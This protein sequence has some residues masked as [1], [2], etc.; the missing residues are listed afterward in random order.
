MEK[1]KY[2]Q[3]N[4]AFAIA[5]KKKVVYLQQIKLTKLNKEYWTLRTAVEKQKIKS[6]FFWR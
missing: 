1:I 4:I 5:Y 6:P 3:K 2:K